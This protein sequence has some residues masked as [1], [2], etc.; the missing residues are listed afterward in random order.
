MALARALTIAGSDSGGGAGIQADL[1]TFTALKV[2]GTSVITCVTAQNTLGVSGVYPL[3]PEQVGAQL[4]A[5]LSDIGTGAAKTG[6]L[7]DTGIIRVVSDRVRRFGVTDLVVDPVMIA[8]GGHPLLLPEAQQAVRE[9][10]LPLAAVVTPNLPEAEALTGMTIRSREEM[11]AAGR[12]LLTM[13]A[14]A[15]VVKGGHFHGEDAEDLLIAADGSQRWFHAE[16]I[17]TRHTHGTGCTFSAAITAGLAHGLGLEQ[18]VE[19]AKEFIT[20]AIAMAPGIGAGHGP[21]NH[22]AWL[23]AE[24]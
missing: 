1:K 16:R 23:E 8:K 14:R 6:M 9:L 20:L 11:V 17:E 5:V 4:D 7:Y 12:R 10:L 3:S 13:G 18:A 24:R 21:T 15:A 2:F 19:Q 22:L